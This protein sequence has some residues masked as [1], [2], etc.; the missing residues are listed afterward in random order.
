MYETQFGE[1]DHGAG[2]GCRADD[3]RLSGTTPWG[4]PPRETSRT[5]PKKPRQTP[6]RRRRKPGNGG[7][8][9]NRRS[10][11]A[12]D[13][14]ARHRGPRPTSARQRDG[15]RGVASGQYGRRRGRRRSEGSLVPSTA[16][17]TEGGQFRL[18]VRFDGTIPI[19]G[20]CTISLSDSG[21]HAMSDVTAT[22][23]GFDASTELI[24]VV[25]D[26][27]VTDDR[28]ITATLVSCDLPTSTATRSG[29]RTRPRSWFAT[30]IPVQGT[31]GVPSAT[32][33]QQPPPEPAPDWT[34]VN[35]TATLSASSR[36][37]VL[38]GERERVA[39]PA[40][41]AGTPMGP[42]ASRS[43]TRWCS[44]TDA[45]PSTASS[46]RP[47]AAAA[48]PAGPSVPP[49]VARGH[50]RA[51]VSRGIPRDLPDHRRRAV[52]HGKPLRQLLDRLAVKRHG[53]P[54]CGVAAGCPAS[55]GSDVHRHLGA[56]AG[57]FQLGRS[58]HQ[59]RHQ[60]VDRAHS[61]RQVASRRTFRNS[62][63]R[64]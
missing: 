49:V 52:H 15:H 28:T 43:T 61:A 4:V 33:Q 5:R 34:P 46:G 37:R 63:T 22:A 36:P 38:V 1:T 13:G 56:L 42:T 11:R 25:D 44:R 59:R 10:A 58:L 57:A 24:T 64:G 21:G 30:M 60:A 6:R 51:G 16:I 39:E 40:G 29:N 31:G 17:V 20:T 23:N 48:A 32:W 8:G 18:M 54:G 14:A 9:G 45:T 2:T 41:T 27:A 35:A 26:D 3:G 55:P 7:A 47:S 53:D 62:T 12:G 19:R 50:E